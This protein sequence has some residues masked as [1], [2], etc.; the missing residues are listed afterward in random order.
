MPVRI[1]VVVGRS[2]IAAHTGSL[3]QF[4]AGRGGAVGV[5]VRQPAGLGHVFAAA[6]APDL[7]DLAQHAGGSLAPGRQALRIEQIVHHHEAVAV[8]DAGGAFDLVRL[9]DFQ[10]HDAVLVAQAGA[11]GFHLG[12]VVGAGRAAPAGRCGLTQGQASRDGPGRPSSRSAG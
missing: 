9:A 5:A 11:Q 2:I 4:A 7:E 1:G 6:F 3:Q 8:E 12:M 10:S